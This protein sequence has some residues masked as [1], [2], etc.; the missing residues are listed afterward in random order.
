MPAR[1]EG[2]EEH[3]AALARAG[4]RAQGALL[5]FVVPEG[6]ESN[7]APVI[8]EFH[9]RTGCR[10]ETISVSVDDV[11]SHL[12]LAVMGGERVDL[13]LP[14]SFAIPSLVEAGTLR[15]LDDFDAKY[16]DP[17]GEPQT[18][19]SLADR[20]GQQRFGF[21]TDGDAYLMFYN[22]A[23]LTDAKLAA[24]YAERY[25]EQLA[26][27]ET[28]QQLDR[29]MA[30]FHEP[31]AE[32][33]GGLLFRTPVYI[34]WE[35][36]LRLHAMGS[37]PFDEDMRPQI[38]SAAGIAA[39]E[40]LTLA[41]QYQ[42]PGA[43]SFGLFENWKAY[44]AGNT[45]AN[46][47]WGGSQKYFRQ[48]PQRFA[49][50]LVY[51]PVPGGLLGGK[52]VRFSYF[53]WGWNYTIPRNSAHPELAYL[54][55]RFA[56]SPR[57]STLAVRQP[58]GFFDPFLPEHYADTE[59][60]HA[61]GEDFLETHRTCMRNAIPDLYLRGRDQY[62]AILSSALAAVNARQLPPAAALRRVSLRW[63]E[64]TNQYGRDKQKAAWASLRQ[65]YPKDV[66]SALS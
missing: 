27:P 1:A 35:Y 15:A 14:A 4:E 38:D 49:D 21:Q 60:Q 66:L 37:L 44:S 51:A 28:W 22:R 62:I 46:I 6:C 48:H 65:R 43:A 63:E 11:S 53:N 29:M 12:M 13:A 23:M 2:S 55:A 10:V 56:T 64:L 40:A 3:Y 61:Y 8:A 20:Y 57:I 47:G 54:F 31:S 33:F 19:Y 32:R 30:F 58:D 59:I 45:F 36:W 18:L 50:G 25:G 7:I 5:R 41:S 34:A 42:H 52:N 16:K 9:A 26:V 24:K 39:L 17:A